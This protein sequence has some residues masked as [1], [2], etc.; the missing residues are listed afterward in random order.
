MENGSVALAKYEQWKCPDLYGEKIYVVMMGGLHIEKAPWNNVGDLLDGSVW[1]TALTESEVASSGTVDSLLKVSH[2]TRTR[3]AH[4]VTVL[5]L[6]RLLN[7]AFNQRSNV[8]ESL[9][10]WLE[11]M[12]KKFPSFKFW[13][14]V[15]HHEI[16][17]LIF[18]RAHRERKFTL[19]VTVLEALVLL[20]FVLDHVNYSRWLPVHIRD[21]KALPQE[22][23][24]ETRSHCTV[25]KSLHRYSAIPID[26]AHEQ[27]NKVVKASGGAVGLRIQLPSDAGLPLDPSLPDF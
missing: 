2:I 21:M 5:V 22:I 11:Q 12:C 13:N 19:H 27:E 8:D 26:Q 6:Q 20:F 18:V 24:D 16:L 15:A 3:H 23:K 10:N 17:I 14:M 7:E 9:S 1:T 25:A 4:K